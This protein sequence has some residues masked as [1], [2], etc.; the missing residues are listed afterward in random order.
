MIGIPM[1]ELKDRL[2][3]VMLVA[4]GDE[5]GKKSAKVACSIARFWMLGELTERPEPAPACV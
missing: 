5:Q 4:I 2:L 3:R 1:T